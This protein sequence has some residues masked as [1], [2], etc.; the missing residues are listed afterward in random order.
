MGKW[1]SEFNV[2]LLFQL[3]SS[4]YNVKLLN[5]KVFVPFFFGRG[6]GGGQGVQDISIC[7]DTLTGFQALAAAASS[8]M[9]SQFTSA[10]RPLPSRSQRFRSCP[11]I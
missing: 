1:T 6:L 5:P 3:Q 7:K 4:I 11:V 2:F 8:L 9:F 10:S